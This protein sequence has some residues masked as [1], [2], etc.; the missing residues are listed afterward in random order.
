MQESNYQVYLQDS[1]KP[2]PYYDHRP[3]KWVGE[4]SWPSPNVDT[5][6]LYLNQ[7]NDS[8]SGLSQ[9]AQNEGVTSIC[10]PQTVGLAG[11][12]YMPWFAFGP[13]E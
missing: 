4:P 10:S 3:G 5:R 8:E 7:A 6:T 13:I 1:V 2:K 12:E 9:A 11:G